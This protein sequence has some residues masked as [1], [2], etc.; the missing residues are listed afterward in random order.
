MDWSLQERQEGA[1]PFTLHQLAALRAVGR[2]GSVSAAA[3]ALYMSQP[4]LSQALQKLERELELPL[5]NRAQGRSNLSLT[6]AGQLLLHFADRYASL[7]KEA[8]Q[9]LQ[10]LRSEDSASLTLGASQTTGTYLVPPLLGNYRRKHPNVA[11][12]LIV[13]STR[14]ICYGV[15][16][17]EI[18]V[19]IVGGAIPS[20]LN[21]VLQSV[22]Y[23]EDELVL[24][25]PP[26][27]AMGDAVWPAALKR[28]SKATEMSQEALYDLNFVS[29][30]ESSS[31]Q[32]FQQGAL[33]DSGID[34]AKLDVVMELN[35]VEAIKNA[36]Q[37][38]LGAAFVSSSAIEKELRLGLLRRVSIRG[39]S[40]LRT[41]R[42]VTNNQRYF[43]RPAETFAQEMLTAADW[44]SM[45]RA[46]LEPQDTRGSLGRR[47]APSP[48]PGPASPSPP[49]R[50]PR[51]SPNK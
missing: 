25:L 24:I 30:N 20:D 46:M 39:V 49:P 8:L 34:A 37:N 12:Q 17:G 42:V 28:G 47:L 10:D 44:Q 40:I 18:D 26:E 21:K 19:A 36:V 11:V 2:A 41:I 15:A 1:P 16:M 22:T 50:A 23:C 48:G 32:A 35:S 13:D 38:G 5:V 9:A 31:V 29:L 43:S 27:S 14:H 33:G 6:E 4:A 51:D 3:D 45:S 7:S